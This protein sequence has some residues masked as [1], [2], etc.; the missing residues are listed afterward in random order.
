VVGRPARWQAAA[1]ARCRPASGFRA[2]VPRPQRV[3]VLRSDRQL[4]PSAA[5]GRIEAAERS[6]RAK[7]CSASARSVRNRLGCQPRWLGWDGGRPGGSPGASPHLP[8]ECGERLR[9]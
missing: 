1:I 3:K 4:F 7:A 6:A 2:G 9:Q 8:E 5:R